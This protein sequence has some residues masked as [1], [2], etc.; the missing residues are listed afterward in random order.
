MI[1]LF[2]EAHT[3]TYLMPGDVAAF[4]EAASFPIAPPSTLRGFIE[5]LAGQER[6]WF[7]GEVA[8]GWAPNEDGSYEPLGSGTML[9]QATQGSAGFRKE[10]GSWFSFRPIHKPLIL[11]PRYRVLIKASEAQETQ[12]R[13]GMEGEA[14]RYGILC[15][16]KS[17]DVVNRLEEVP[18]DAPALWLTD[19]NALR[20][21]VGTTTGFRNYSPVYKTFD[22]G[23]E[24][25]WISFGEDT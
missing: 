11:R 20:L 10:F 19:G 25:Y 15:L 21:T 12:I 17:D 7:Q 6:G 22:Y 13:K 9:Q 3:G 24:P 1:S 2:V 16:G 14:D 23:E 4:C 8:Y 5:S 18:E